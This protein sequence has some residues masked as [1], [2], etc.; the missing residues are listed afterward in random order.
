MQEQPS[1]H[2]DANTA[3]PSRYSTPAETQTD[4]T[5]RIIIIIIGCGSIGQ[6]IL[7]VSPV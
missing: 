7:R 1:G 3:T 4:F 6:G 2:D 5:G